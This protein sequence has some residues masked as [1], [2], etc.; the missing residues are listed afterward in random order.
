MIV[1]L[2]VVLLSDLNIV[3]LTA[4]QLLRSVTFLNFEFTGFQILRRRHKL[5][6]RL[7]AELV[8]DTCQLSV[9]QTAL[10]NNLIVHK[11]LE[12]LPHFRGHLQIL[13]E[14]MFGLL[15]LK[16]LQFRCLGEVLLGKVGGDLSGDVLLGDE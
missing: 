12:G 9:D 5:H 10:V 4:C 8:K 14:Q 2:S 3:E 13:R 1:A 7:C 11:F 6:V 15:I 16:R